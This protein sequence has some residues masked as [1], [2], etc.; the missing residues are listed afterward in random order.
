MIQGL[1]GSPTQT[2]HFTDKNTEAQSREGISPRS[3]KKLG[4]QGS[5]AGLGIGP[6]RLHQSLLALLLLLSIAYLFKKS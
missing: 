6:S 5:K 2:C 1:K 3:T 4:V